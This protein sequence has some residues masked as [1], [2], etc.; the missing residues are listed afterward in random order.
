MVK[1]HVEA[2][3]KGAAQVLAER[4]QVDMSHAVPIEPHAVLAQWQGERVTIWSTSQVP[5]LDRAGV[6]ETLGIPES[7][8]RIIVPHLGGGFGGKCEFHFEA[9]VAA[10]ARKARRPVRRVFSR[11]EEFIAPDKVNH[12]ILID[13]KTGVTRD[14]VMTARSARIVLDTDRKSTRL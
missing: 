11:H 8:V 14:G 7:R 5:F 13:L 10:L 12:P 6:A 9:H 3:L 2:G 4:Y 1:G